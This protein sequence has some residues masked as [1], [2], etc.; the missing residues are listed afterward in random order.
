MT[1]KLEQAQWERL[2]DLFSKAVEL[3]TAE[4]DAFVLRETGDDPEL[5]K[6][7]LELL[8]CDSGVSTGPLTH[9]LGAALDATSRERRKALVGKSIGNYR[10]VSVL[11]H[12]GT[13]TVYLAERADRQ[14][15][16]QVAI[17]VVDTATVHGD[18]GARFR[19]ERQILA[20][21]NHPNIGR[22][23][24]AGETE[25]GQPY[26]VMEYIHGEQLDRYADRQSPCRLL[27]NTLSA[28]RCES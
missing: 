20:S 16:A 1:G 9:A 11:G 2:Q 6:E 14:Y 21:L 10:L 15:S 4:R 25:E 8:E 17:K 23:L 26:L 12:G 27:W 13:G 19:A 22:L 7:L 28:G 24:D 18:L 3:S 5:R